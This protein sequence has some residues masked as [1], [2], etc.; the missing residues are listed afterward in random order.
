MLIVIITVLTP[1]PE[2]LFGMATILNLFSAPAALQR[3]LVAQMVLAP[4]VALFWLKVWSPFGDY[5]ALFALLFMGPMFAGAVGGF[6]AAQLFRMRTVRGAT[7]GRWRISALA[8]H[9]VVG[10]VVAASMAGVA[11]LLYLGYPAGAWCCLSV[12]QQEHLCSVYAETHRVLRAAD[13]PYFVCFGSALG[14]LREAE[15]RPDTMMMEWEHDIDICV[16]EE[17]VERAR[18]ALAASDAIS[19]AFFNQAEFGGVKLQGRT[20]ARGGA[21]NDALARRYV[22]VFVMAAREQDASFVEHFH[23]PP[24]PPKVLKGAPRGDVLPL[25]KT[26]FCGVPDAPVPR[27]LQPYVRALFGADYNTLR[28]APGIKKWMC[29]FWLSQC[30]SGYVARINR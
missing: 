3:A 6:A 17:D 18:S 5:D 2:G 26:P 13:V 12:Q 25:A 20:Y 14:I 16:F 21:F 7:G 27:N 22:D 9:I 19:S 15:F 11:A 1:S 29:R 24:P 28:E 8:R 10:E 23:V 4:T 30:S